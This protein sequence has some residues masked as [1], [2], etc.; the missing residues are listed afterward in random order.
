MF[1]GVVILFC[2]VIFVAY[3]LFQV[4]SITVAGCSSLSEEQVETLSG[5]KYGECIFF[6]DT[7]EV[8]EALAAN[9]YVE[10]VSVRITYPYTV[11]IEIRERIPA[12]YVDVNGVRLTIDSAAVVLAVDPAPAGEVS[13]TVAGFSTDRFELGQPLGE[14]AYKREVFTG[15]LSALAGSGL[16]IVR[17]D[18]T[19]TVS[20]KIITRDGF[21]IQL[22]DENALAG[23]LSLAGDMINQMAAQGRNGG[24]I[25]VSTGETAYYREN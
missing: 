5:L 24:V 14:D 10:P 12:A 21:T 1:V 6:V 20:M 4:R 13:P 23:K 8:K 3:E 2:A 16:D 17:I 7:E 11:A 25:D 9:P 15:L 22:G 18:M 19:Y